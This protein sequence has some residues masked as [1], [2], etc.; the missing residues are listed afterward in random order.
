MKTGNNSTYHEPLLEE[1]IGR[2]SWILHQIS[3][4]PSIPDLFICDT[5]TTW[6]VSPINKPYVHVGNRVGLDYFLNIPSSKLDWM[7]P[8]HP[9]LEKYLKVSITQQRNP[10]T[11]LQVWNPQTRSTLKISFKKVIVKHNVNCP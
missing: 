5:S 3:F 1:W 4:N 2:R 6:I 8:Q 10:Q 9:W 11:K 7:H